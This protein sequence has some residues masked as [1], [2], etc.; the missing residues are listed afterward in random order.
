M[1]IGKPYFS[2]SKLIKENFEKAITFI[3][4]FESNA[5]DYAKTKGSSSVICGHI[6]IPVMKK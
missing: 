4:D 6:H 2:I 1:K 3:S 5:C